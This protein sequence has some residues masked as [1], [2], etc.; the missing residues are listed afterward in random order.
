MIWALLSEPSNQ[1]PTTLVPL[2][3]RAVTE[4][5]SSG[6]TALRLWT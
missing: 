5:W 6:P 3:H 1:P 4:T 2:G